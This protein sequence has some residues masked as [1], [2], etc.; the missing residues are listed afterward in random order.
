MISQ[1]SKNRITFN[2][3]KIQAFLGGCELPAQEH[4][5]IHGLAVETPAMILAP[6]D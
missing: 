1:D 2:K 6:W 4:C 5:K 3:C